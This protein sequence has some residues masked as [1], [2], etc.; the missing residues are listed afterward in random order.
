[1]FGFFTNAVENALDIAEGLC[2]GEL[3]SKR[4]I[5]KLVDAGLSI[6]AISELTGF[7]ED[8]IKEIAED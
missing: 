1:M 8:V 7:A 2:Y 3:P 4:Q 5:A 6:Y